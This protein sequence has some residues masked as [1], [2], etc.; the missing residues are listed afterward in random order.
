MDDLNKHHVTAIIATI[1]LGFIGLFGFS[2]AATIAIIGLTFGKIGWIIV[3][4]KWQGVS[5][6]WKTLSE[7]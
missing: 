3:A 1:V 4:A 7:R 2:V 5:D 6:L